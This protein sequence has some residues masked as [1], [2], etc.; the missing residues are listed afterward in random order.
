MVDSNFE[1][2]FTFC[3]VHLIKGCLVA[4]C[5]EMGSGFVF[6]ANSIPITV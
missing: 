2:S 1:Y 6:F 3:S 5:W 4:N